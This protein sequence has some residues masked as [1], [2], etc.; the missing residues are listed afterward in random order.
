MAAARG[1]RHGAR[2]LEGWHCR[3]EGQVVKDS[4]GICL[5]GCLLSKCLPRAFV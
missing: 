2:L 4:W 5:Y 3:D 1:P